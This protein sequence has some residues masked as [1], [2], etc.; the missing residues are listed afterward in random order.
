MYCFPKLHKNS[1]CFWFII[2]SKNWS[3]KP[4]SKVVSNVSKII[5]FPIEISH[6]KS[7]FLSNYNKFLV[8]QSVDPVMENIN[9]TNRKKN[10]KSVA[11]VCY[12][13]L[14][15]AKLIKSL[16]NVIDFVFEGGNRTNICISK[17]VPYWEKK[18]KDYIA[19]SK[20]TL[21]SSLKDLTQNCYFMVENSLPIQ[22][23]GIPMGID[24]EPY[25][26]NLF[27]NTC[28][29]EY[30]SELIQMKN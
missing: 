16:C 14:L 23:I 10:A 27:L 4:L 9:I 29:N 12:T 21:K 3:T 22:K 8:L 17:N 6:R 20:S 19:F 1:V 11:T 13:T 15:R 24:P 28:E 18:P 2:A 7:K 5:Y 26:E 30:T 25:F